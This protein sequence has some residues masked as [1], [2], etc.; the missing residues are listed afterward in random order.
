MSVGPQLTEQDPSVWRCVLMF[1]NAF[2]DGGQGIHAR[3][4]TR[5]GR[6]PVILDIEFT[7]NKP[8]E[9]TAAVF[10]GPSLGLSIR[11]AQDRETAGAFRWGFPLAKTTM[12]LQGGL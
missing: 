4:I 12:R 9:M 5:A 6:K 1:S 10:A 7:K 2:A 8:S 3:P 11:I